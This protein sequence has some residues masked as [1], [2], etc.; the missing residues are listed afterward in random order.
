M[1]WERSTRRSWIDLRARIWFVMVFVLLPSLG[2]IVINSVLVRQRARTQAQADLLSLAHQAGNTQKQ[3]LEEM[4][5]TLAL[6]ATLTPVLEAAQTGN[7]GPCQARLAQIAALY[8]QTTGFRVWDLKGQS[9]C[10]DRPLTEPTNVYGQLW[11][12]QVLDKQSFAIGEFELSHANGEVLIAF[13]YPVSNTSGGLAAVVSSGFELFHL[14]QTDAT[15]PWPPDAFVSEFDHNGIVLARSQNATA[16]IGKSLPEA[17]GLPNSLADGRNVIELTESDGVRR[18]YAVTPVT[19]PGGSLIYLSISRPANAVFG[20]SDTALATSLVV[21]VGLAVMALALAGWW[22]RHTM[23]R[24]MQ[25]LLAATNRLA[26]GDLSTRARP[27]P[28]GS[29]VDLLATTFN[30]MAANLELREEARK[31]A[32]QYLR[33][34]EARFRVWTDQTTQLLQQSQARVAQLETVMAGLSWAITPAETMDVILHQ[35]AGAVGAIAATLLLLSE[36]GAW[37]KQAVSAGHPDQ[38]GRLFQRFPVSS[39]LPASDVARTGESVWI[40]SAAAYRARYPQLTEL[41][42]TTDY[43]AA[44]AVPLR[45]AGQLIGVLVLSFPGV[46]TF[47]SEIQNYIVALA[48]CCANALE[49]A[50]L[51]EETQRLNKALEARDPQGRKEGLDTGAIEGGARS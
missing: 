37:L 50:R 20:P 48:S 26:T 30:A 34:S 9:I 19:G 43:E 14:I 8:P 27:E 7:V 22:S 47:T 5:R 40:E 10:A 17:A 44:V 35:G 6:V 18:L 36:D 1:K 2:Y 32:E 28:A 39:P 15:L 23:V 51:F 3:G 41:I 33:E 4:Q 31:K 46:I 13:G 21:S 11:F 12:R 49:R 29:E 45:Y 24:P 38:I 25:A 16:W 42:D